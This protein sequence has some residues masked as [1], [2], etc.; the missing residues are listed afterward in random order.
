MDLPSLPE[1]VVMMAIEPRRG[2]ESQQLATQLQLL[3][4]NN[5]T[6]QGLHA[7]EKPSWSQ[8]DPGHK[9]CIWLSGY[10]DLR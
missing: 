6:F 2:I 8:R 7:P 1:C 3:G 5:Q 10:Q 9:S 4:E